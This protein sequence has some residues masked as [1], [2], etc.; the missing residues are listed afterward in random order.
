MAKTIKRKEKA[1]VCVMCGVRDAAAAAAADA[2][3]SAGKQ[4][5]EVG[6]EDKRSGRA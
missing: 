2:A 3:A 4:P 1:K 6:Q 5:Q